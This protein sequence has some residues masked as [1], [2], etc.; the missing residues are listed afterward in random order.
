[1]GYDTMYRVSAV[2]DVAHPSAM[3]APVVDAMWCY[4]AE[5][6]NVDM[7][8]HESLILLRLDWGS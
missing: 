8:C 1:V 3:S 7:H 6:L 5:E 4:V 2:L